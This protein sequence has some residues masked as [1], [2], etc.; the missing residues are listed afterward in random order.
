MDT[1]GLQQLEL[2]CDA[3]YNSSSESERQQAQQ[4]LLSLQS[5]AEYIPQCQYILDHSHSSYALFVAANA[6]TKLITQYWNNFSVA[7]RVEI[8]NYV[9]SYLANQGHQVPD[10]VTTSLI[11]LVCRITKLGWFDDP[12]HRELVE[13]VEKFLHAN[14]DYCIVGLR[15]LNQVVEEFNLPTSGRTLTLHRKTAVSFRDLCLFHIFQICLSTLQ[16]VQRRQFAN[17][18][19]QQEVKIAEQ[20]LALSVRALSFDF[21]GT[22]PDESAEDVGTIQVPNTW[23]R[24]VQNPETMS[25]FLDFYKNT[26]PPSSSLA[27]QAV[28]LLSSVRRSLFATDKDRAA[29][30]QQLVTAIREILQTEQG[31]NFQENYHEFCRLLGRLKANYQLCELVRTEGF[32]E[33]CDL[34]AAFTVRS[35][36]QWQWFGNSIHYLL[37][38]WGRLIAAIPYVPQQPAGS[39]SG[40]NGGGKNYRE[41]MQ[42]CVLQVVQSYIKCMVDSVEVVVRSDGGLEDP[43]DDEGSLKDQLER[44]PVI[45][46][47]QYPAV[48]QYLM[49]FLDPLLQTYREKVLKNLPPAQLAAT[50]PGEAASQLKILDGQLT[51]L[52]YVVGAIIGGHTSEIHGTSSSSSDSGALSQESMDANLASR[53]LLLAQDFNVRAQQTG[54]PGPCSPRLELALVSFFQSFRKMYASEM[55]HMLSMS[56]ASLSAAIRMDAGGGMM[57]QKAYQTV[58]DL[59]GLG[60]QVGITTIIVTKVRSR[61]GRPCGR[62]SC[63][64]PPPLCVVDLSRFRRDASAFSTA[65]SLCTGCP[66][67]KN[68]LFFLPPPGR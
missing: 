33:W 51:W 63:P 13:D 59:M 15:I 6:L 44:L 43:L 12:Q 62:L 56:P 46:L 18:S 64:P 30:L 25:L 67:Y 53:C 38:L 37:G 58:Y 14:V 28:I 39:A 42:R 1:Q 23:R 48:A 19:P 8:R 2:L 24:L 32:N 22:N 68:L 17:A 66:A 50:A 7:Q 45:C 31:L 65:S 5:S 61:V 35:F 47:F 36:Q 55:P 49:S 34:A 54:G 52:V 26:Q 40:A 3:L 20:A 27:L 29:F 21:I 11:Q 9:L 16:Q 10:F 57:K 41:N 60:D 4:Q